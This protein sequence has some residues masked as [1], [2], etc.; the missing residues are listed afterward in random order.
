MIQQLKDG[1]DDSIRDREEVHL[2]KMQNFERD[3]NKGLPSLNRFDCVCGH[4]IKKGMRHLSAEL[5]LL[6]T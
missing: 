3:K 1:F 5:G 4:K 6:G 2:C